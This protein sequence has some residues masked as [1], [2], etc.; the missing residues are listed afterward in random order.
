MLAPGAVLEDFWESL[1]QIRLEERYEHVPVHKKWASDTLIFYADD[2]S[3]DSFSAVEGFAADFFR[4][5]FLRG[6][7]VRGCLTVG[8]LYIDEENGIYFGP[9]FIEAYDVAEGQDWVGFILTKRA[10]DR[11]LSYRVGDL[12][13]L[14]V[15]TQYRYR[16]YRVPFK[17]HGLTGK[18]SSVVR[19]VFRCG[20]GRKA[21]L[22]AYTMNIHPSPGNGRRND[23]IRLWNALIDMQVIARDIYCKKKK[24]SRKVNV[25]Y[26]NTKSFLLEIFA[27]LKKLAKDRNCPIDPG[28][29]P[30]SSGDDRWAQSGKF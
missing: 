24:E 16:E 1:S 6:I 9:G 25:K 29:V 15:C 8:K 3:C 21:V 5:M 10:R 12:S 28:L 11:I 18:I 4:S 2:D 13:A 19:R 27:E 17:P 20:M 30:T 7:P 23:S 26:E 14:D 22:P